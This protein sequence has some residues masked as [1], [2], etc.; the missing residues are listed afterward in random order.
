VGSSGWWQA[1]HEA[2]I[3]RHCS[4]R[5]RQ[6]GEL[7]D[8]LD[9][10]AATL[11]AHVGCDPAS[12]AARPAAWLTDLSVGSRGSSSRTSRIPQAPVLQSAGSVPL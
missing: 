2:G 5:D 12:T 10:T 6:L 9:V 1:E 11:L 7:V 4:V 3:P 8:A